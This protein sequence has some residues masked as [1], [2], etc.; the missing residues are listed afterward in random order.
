M[1][2]ISPIA[3]S[4][5]KLGPERVSMS[6]LRDGVGMIKANELRRRERVKNAA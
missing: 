2:I 5:P 6:K 3:S 1:L 4:N